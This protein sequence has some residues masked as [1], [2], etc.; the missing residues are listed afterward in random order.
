VQEALC[1]MLLI[2]ILLKIALLLSTNVVTALQITIQ[3]DTI[4]GQPSLVLWMR[5]S[6]DGDGELV[7]DLRFVQPGPQDVGLAVSNIQASSDTQFGSV[8]VVFPSPGLYQLVAVS[9]P[10]DINLG[11]SN[12][13]NAIVVSS[14]GPPPSSPTLSTP[15]TPSPTHSGTASASAS[16]SA[17]PTSALGSGASHSN[18]TGSI[19]GGIFATLII[20]GLLVALVLYV[21]RRKANNNKRRTLDPTF[22]PVLMLR[23]SDLNAT[24]KNPD[25][26][27]TRS[28]ISQS[29]SAAEIERLPHDDI[30]PSLLRRPGPVRWLP[31]VR[32]LIPRSRIRVEPPV[33][34]QHIMELGNSPGP[35]E[36][37][38]QE[39]LHPETRTSWVL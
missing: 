35:P 32:P 37:T 28:I 17:H 3:S 27:R 9:G 1:S 33:I 24:P 8:Q 23:P 36:H 10:D 16:A 31:D 7:F 26:Y 22:D 14:N 4:V 29:P 20:L 6:S 39:T 15:S 5:D 11:E 34:D 30:P 38:H 19:V 13:V 21:R 25:I 18:N 2:S 12:Q